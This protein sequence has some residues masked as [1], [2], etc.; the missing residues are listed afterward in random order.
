MA[1][2]KTPD[3]SFLDSAGNVLFFSK[4]RFVNDICLGRCCFICGAQPGSKVFNDEHIIP[5]WVLRK[6]NL[7]DRTITLPNN[8]TIKYSRYKVPCCEGCNSLMGRQIEQRISTVVNAG[9]EAIQNHIANGNSLEF[10]V[11][12]GLIFLKTHLKDRDFRIERD[13]RE[14]DHKISDLYDWE[15]LHHLHCI[16]RCF[17]NGSHLDKEV[18]GSLGAFAA[19]SEG[20]LDEFDYGDL[21]EAQTMLL[22]LG[23]V[24]L[25]TTFN[26][27]CGAINGAMPRLERIAGPLSEIQA[28]EVM[29][30][31][32]FMN[33]SLKERPQFHTECDLKNETLAERAVMPAQFKLGELDF[34]LRGALFRHALSD[35]IA[36]MRALGK[37]KDEIE[38]AV[39]DGR[40]TVLFDDNGK[41]IEKSI[42]FLPPETTLS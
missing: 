12:L 16:V 36:T 4:E 21:I 7:F 38:R 22:R 3:G 10:F 24:V 40:F 11:W 9:P 2:T 26:D 30:D 27:A 14:S 18:L 13:L 5:E 19:K 37:T 15:T 42:V 6:Y 1:W 39:D 41:F 31:F 28:R 29:V 8:T 34:A 33:L 35:R 25:I 23:D 20:S 17:V 32:A